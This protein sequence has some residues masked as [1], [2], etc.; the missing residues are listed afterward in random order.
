MKV[1]QIII[2]LF[3]ASSM[4][5][6]SQQFWLNKGKISNQNLTKCSFVDTL[7]GWAVGDSG[8]IIYT[9]NGGAS[10]TIQNSKIREYMTNVFFL[11][12]RLGWAIGW[13][14]NPDFYG[15]YI[16]KTTNGGN[17]WDTSRYHVPDTYIRTIY[18]MDSL[19]GF[20]GGGPAT[21]LKTTNAGINWYKC[22][23]D[24]TNVASLFPVSK[25]RFYSRNYGF[26]FGGVMD[27][28]GVVWITTNNG[29][30][31]DAK[32]VAPEPITDAKFY[33]SLHAVAIGG[34]YEYGASILKTTNG[35]VNWDYKNMEIF[36]VPR[37]L[38]FRTESE[39]WAAMGD[40][41]KFFMT[42][43][44]GSS[45]NEVDTPDTAR[46]FDVTFIN[47]KFGVGV[48]MFGVFVKF[49]SAL[50]NIGENISSVNKF[51]LKQNYPNP[52]NPN[53]TIEYVISDISRVEIEVYNL[54]GRETETIYKGIK[55]PGE[56][57]VRFSGSSYPSG[58]YFYRLIIKDIKTG[59]TKAITKKMVL[60]K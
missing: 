22:G 30:F 24:T 53:T 8:T 16:L 11:N 14:L 36:G 15:T 57:K 50:I 44:S 33:D 2:I 9:S 21:L 17:T 19:T 58:I 18:F 32:I 13:G 1:F 41:P 5:A 10:W 60:L 54:L 12:K 35:G 26:A 6:L 59:N 38:S 43:D 4:D 47:N 52:F 28:A 34:D 48:G 55:P 42:L 25:F 56:Y 46:V 51:S 31:W 37:A 3:L 23:I 29:N 45:W 20:M 40:L 49:N 27:I 39:G 7:N